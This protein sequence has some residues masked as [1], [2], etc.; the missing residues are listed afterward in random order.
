MNHFYGFLTKKGKN[1]F[2]ITLL[3]TAL[4]FASCSSDGNSGGGDEKKPVLVIKG[5]VKASSEE[6][7]DYETDFDSAIPGFSLKT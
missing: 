5:D 3:S 4:L 7:I 2:L 1:I 6:G